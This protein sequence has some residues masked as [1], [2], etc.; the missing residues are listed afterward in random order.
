MIGFVGN[1]KIKRSDFGMSPYP[2]VIADEVELK[3]A[4]ELVQKPGRRHGGAFSVTMTAG[5]T[6]EGVPS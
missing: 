4:L 6:I 2:A 3:I 1:T 5:H